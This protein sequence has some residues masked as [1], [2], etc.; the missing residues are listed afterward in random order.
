LKLLLD[1][2]VVLWWVRDDRRLGRDARRAIATADFVWVSAASGWEVATLVAKRHLRVAEPLRVTV[3][4]DSFTELPFTLRHAEEL[5]RLPFHHRDPFDRILMAQ[6]RV[7][8]A[9]IVSH[10]R[11]LEPYGVPMIWT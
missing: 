8:G 3:S 6:A 1:T 5:Q 11:D 4:A 10:D 9:T 2:H 7:E